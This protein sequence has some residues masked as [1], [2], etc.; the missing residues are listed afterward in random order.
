MAK[1]F[2]FDRLVQQAEKQKQEAEEKAKNNKVENTKIENKISKSKDNKQESNS[3][4][5][6]K[7]VI[8]EEFKNL[9]PPL[10]IEEY[11]KLE[12]NILAE[13]CRDPLVF[14]K[15]ED[16]Y[17]LIDGHNRYG[18]CTHHGLGFKTEVKNFDND[19]QV[20]NWMVANQLGKRNVSEETKSYL[21][22]LQYNQEKKKEKGN[23]QNLRQ[24]S[25]QVE[26]DNLTSSGS[27]S[28][29]LAE[30]H[31]VSEK[32]I[33]RDEKYALAI[34]MLVDEDKELK[35]NILNKNINLPKGKVMKLADQ[36]KDKV[37]EIGKRLSEGEKFK[38]AF[39]NILQD[40]KSIKKILKPRDEKLFN[41]KSN[42]IS[43]INEAIKQNNK[44]PLEEMKE[45]LEKL[46]EELD[47]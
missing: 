30:Q 10:T 19:E 5:K 13:G 2:K 28:E 8:R 12:D 27:T 33:K 42:I 23:T 17:I 47:N 24:F 34:D 37:R 3:F 41:L 21:R 31:K 20:R 46:E 18:I 22:G 6:E 32:T 44:E 43:C 11:A 9:I 38:E 36:D 16:K 29:R 4:N 35:W 40:T 1:K 25:N 7:I 45:Y 14:W 15:K 39:E 26:G